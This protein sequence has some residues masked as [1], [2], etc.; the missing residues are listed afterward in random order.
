MSSL[1]DNFH[2][3]Y[4]NRFVKA[5]KEIAFIK[6]CGSV[7]FVI[8]EGMDFVPPTKEQ[9]KNL[10]TTFNIDIEVLENLKGGL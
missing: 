10:K 4:D 3:A 6:I 7:K 5:P 8:T 1:L 2:T 9:I